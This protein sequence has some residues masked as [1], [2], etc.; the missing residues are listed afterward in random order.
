[1]KSSDASYFVTSYIQNLTK[2]DKDPDLYRYSMDKVS[3][4][5]KIIPFPGVMFVLDMTTGR[6]HYLSKNF[7]WSAQHHYD[8]LM[9]G[10]IEYL[11]QIFNRNDLKVHDQ[12]MMENFSFLKSV[13]HTEISDYWFTSNF[14]IKVN[15]K[16]DHHILQH[17][18]VNDADEDN[19]PR[20]IIG[21]A[22]DINMFKTNSVI[23]DTI[24][25]FSPEHGLVPIHTKTIF[26]DKELELSKRE[27]EIARLI[28]TGMNN[29]QIAD[30]LYISFHTAKTHRKNIYEKT[31]CKN[32]AELCQYGRALF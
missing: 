27:I 28:C 31:N 12:M 4:I 17:Y 9:E 32:V 8:P 13:P 15:P 25:K 1:M 2:L 29:H 3:Q 30:R 26:P 21:M 18:I 11:Y 14:R 7:P 6:Y 16:V 23:H 5:K 20:M 24:S 19:N 22:V 10:G